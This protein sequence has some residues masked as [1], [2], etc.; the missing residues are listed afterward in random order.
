MGIRFLCQYCQKRIHVK[1]YLAGKKA[2]CP[3]CKG[4][5]R[6]P[7]PASEG[8]ETR[9]GSLDT[10]QRDTNKV[11]SGSA[12]EG[13]SNAFAGQPQDPNSFTLD[14]PEEIDEQKKQGR[15]YTD[16]ISDDPN[17]NWYLRIEDGKQFGP[18]PGPQMRSWVG[19]GRLNEECF[20]WREGWANWRRATDVF[21]EYF[22]ALAAKDRPIFINDDSESS[23]Q[24]IEEPKNRSNLKESVSKKKPNQKR[25]SPVSTRAGNSRWLF[26]GLLLML[27]VVG[28]IATAGLIQLSSTEIPESVAPTEKDDFDS[29]PGE[30]IVDPFAENE[31]QKDS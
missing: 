27:V 6:I 21:P 23:V 17:A 29:Q 20:V 1:S 16:W 9:I 31:Y 8:Q 13:D 18:A 19:E 4:K 30:E 3:H 22:Q 14:K 2:E 5:I 15:E 11:G 25:P 7:D 12:G 26:M 28:G 10:D 24:V